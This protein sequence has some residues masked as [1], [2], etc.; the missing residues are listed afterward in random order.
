MAT[1]TVAQGAFNTG[2]TATQMPIIQ[3][4]GPGTLYLNT[5]S[6]NISTDGLQLPVGAV[7]EFPKV[8]QDGAGAVWIQAIGGDCDVRI[9]NVG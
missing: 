3:N 9:I 1:I 6:T 8:V 5:V 2:S 4:L 7:Y